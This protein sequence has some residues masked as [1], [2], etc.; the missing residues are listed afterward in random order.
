VSKDWRLYAEHIVETVKEIRGVEER[1]DIRR[2]KILYAASLRFLQT[3]AEA[4]QHLPK[5]LKERH[6]DIDW[7]GISGFRNILVHSYLGSSIDEDTVLDI[8]DEQ[9]DPLQR[10]IKTM[11][12]QESGS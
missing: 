4:T 1:G 9:L 10:A 8:I 3:L 2:D 11:L 5:E 6:P 12:E 7:K